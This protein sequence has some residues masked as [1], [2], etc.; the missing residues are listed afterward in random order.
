MSPIITADH[1][2]APSPDELRRQL[3]TTLYATENEVYAKSHSA[4]KRRALAKGKKALP[5]G[6]YP[7][8]DASDLGPALTLI[9]SGH[10]N[11]GAAKALFKRRAKELGKANMIPDDWG[12]VPDD[13]TAAFTPAERSA[14]SDILDRI[15]EADRQVDAA[16]PALAAL[17][18]R[19]NPDTDK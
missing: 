8:E 4:E 19:A 11:V 10:G 7:I 14:L 2:R 16:Q 17:L 9:Q 12:S 13:E 1:H 3:A 6:S 15:A 18:G 5:D